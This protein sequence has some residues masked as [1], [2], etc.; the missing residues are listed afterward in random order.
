[1]YKKKKKREI[2]IYKNFFFFGCAL[3]ISKLQELEKSNLR[4]EAWITR[5]KIFLNLIKE[6]KKKN[7]IFVSP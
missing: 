4:F 3:L 2:I 5:G 6:N 7:I 1:M